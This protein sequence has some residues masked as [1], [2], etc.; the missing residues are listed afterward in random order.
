MFEMI[1]G[2]KAHE[3]GFD[4]NDR[5]IKPKGKGYHSFKLTL[6]NSKA[7][8]GYEEVLMSRSSV[9]GKD[10]SSEKVHV[11]ELVADL[12]RD[13]IISPTTWNLNKA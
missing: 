2:S 10:E 11:S 5:E 4:L 8:R 9:S 13:G 3:S 6:R 12:L 7:F 1:V